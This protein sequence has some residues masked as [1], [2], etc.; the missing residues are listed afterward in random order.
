[1]SEKQ[2]IHALMILEVLGRPKEF[3]VETLENLVKQMDSEQ[4]VV[5]KSKN[6]KEPRK[7]NDN[8]KIAGE[9]KGELKIEEQNDFYVS[10]AEVEIE[11]ETLSNLVFLIFKYMP[12]HIE[13]FSPE[14]IALTNNVWNGVLNDLIL[15]LHGF[16]EVVRV[17]QVEK[18]VL[19]NKL[20]GILEQNKESEKVKKP[21]KKKKK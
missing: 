20:R 15:R 6:I 19:E 1:M 10:F 11:T 7:A 5:V 16:D 12:A 3:L 14:L 9:S 21:A 2:K 17:M 8:P 18:A 4:G 13:I